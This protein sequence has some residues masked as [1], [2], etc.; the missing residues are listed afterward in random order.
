MRCVATSPSP[1]NLRSLR[2][3]RAICGSP[4]LYCQPLGR[5]T[6]STMVS[7]GPSYE[8]CAVFLF[9]HSAEIRRLKGH[10]PRRGQR[11]RSVRGD[12]WFVTEVLRSGRNTYTVTCAGSNEFAEDVLH[13]RSRAL[14]SDLLAVARKTIGSQEGLVPGTPQAHLRGYMRTDNWIEKY[15]SLGP[16]YGAQLALDGKGPESG[17]SDWLDAYLQRCRNQEQHGGASDR[18]W[19][20]LLRAFSVVDHHLRQGA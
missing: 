19:T 18:P 5:G 1:S 12:V 15:L 7:D 10:P 14:A 17:E 3:D 2:L 4:D 8:V 13:R 6:S 16:Q 11:I 9:P 20:R